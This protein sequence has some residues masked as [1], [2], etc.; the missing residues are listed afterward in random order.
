MKLAII[1]KKNEEED[2]NNEDDGENKELYPLYV[3][4]SGIGPF[5]YEIG[6]EYN[7]SKEKIKKS[8]RDYVSNDIH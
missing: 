4:E 8:L 5:T 6:S 1:N 7:L 3:D 2:D